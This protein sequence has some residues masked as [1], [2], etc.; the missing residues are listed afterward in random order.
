[1]SISSIFSLIFKK[2]SVKTGK[3]LFLIVPIALLTALS[4]IAFSQ[5]ANFQKATNDAVFGTIA[6]QNTV[7]QI[8]K[9][10][11]Q[12]GGGF[13]G[14]GGGRGQNSVFSTDDI[15]TVK[16]IENV[17]SASVNYNL[18]INSIKSTNLVDKRTVDFAGLTVATPE[19]GSLYTTEKFEFVEGQ[20]IPIIIN[21]ASMTEQY[22]D[23]GGKD[24]VTISRPQR[25]QPGQQGPTREQRQSINSL[26][27]FK[28]EVITQT[29]EEL[30]NKEFDINFGGLDQLATF[31][32]TVDADNIIYTKLSETDKAARENAR[33]ETISKYWDYTK[34]ST[35]ITYKFKVV[36]YIKSESKR[37][38]YIP[39]AFAEKVMA[40]LIDNQL[41]S[42]NQTPIPVTELGTVYRGVTYNGLTLNTTQ[43]N[44]NRGPQGAAGAP[45]QRQDGATPQTPAT[46]TPT[47]P[48]QA[49]TI[50]GLI[51]QTDSNTN[52][53]QGTLNETDIFSKTSKTSQ[54]LTV[55]FNNIDNKEQV[56]RD[57]NN[58]GF[59][60]VDTSN[61]GVFKDLQSTLTNILRFTPL[62]FGALIAAILGLNMAKTISEGKKEIGI[63]RALGFTK[64]NIIGLFG[65]QGIVY[66]LIGSI[67]GVLLG[68]VGN[69]VIANISYS[70]FQDLVAKT[71]S[72]SFGVKPN[73]ELSQF[74][75]F[76]FGNASLLG[77]VLIILTILISL[78]FSIRASNISPVEAIK[79]E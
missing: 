60:Y 32:N 51:I 26:L 3:A 56:I 69:F 61:S 1:M 21:A 35:P 53:I 12:E 31:N 17:S 15:S 42:R 43:G 71:V 49:Y 75:K 65:L 47:V 24:S 64:G 13:G 33:K 6:S 73:I 74:Q 39:E 22:E 63:M 7:L 30:M 59:A 77:L 27:P 57:L 11:N 54:I 29:K 18:P 52:T 41:A 16:G 70:R 58:K 50:P 23:W 28:N 40:K 72:E 62:L 48:V 34:V 20:P 36:G 67:F 44:A 78:F 2:L 79:A 25:P 46:A 45:G 76:D 10:Q 38:M 19:I 9:A 55:K 5:A 14:G 37:F 8:S 68:L 66:T 4:L